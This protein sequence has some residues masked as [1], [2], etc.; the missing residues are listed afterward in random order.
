MKGN[1]KRKVVAK[2]AREVKLTFEQSFIQAPM[3]PLNT[4]NCTQIYLTTPS[5][6]SI[7]L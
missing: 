2:N 3:R 4:H 6:H 5:L 1:P 7:H